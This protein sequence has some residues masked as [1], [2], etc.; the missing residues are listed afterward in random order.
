MPLLL[1]W[2]PMNIRAICLRLH[3]WLALAAALPLII[4]GLTGAVLTFENELD[5]LLNPRLWNV[6][7]RGERQAWQTL[8]DR[9]HSQ[10]PKDRV[11]S[12]QLPS[13][14]DRAAVIL[15]ELR[16]DGLRRSL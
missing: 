15:L 5:R 9:V 13:G 12:L 1:Q 11:G 2:L 4:L 16:P 6:A 10:Y 8:V 7:N 14:D 3:R